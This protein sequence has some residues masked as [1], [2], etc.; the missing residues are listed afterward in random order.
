MS[1]GVAN[2]RLW[3]LAIRVHS[4]GAGRLYDLFAEL[5]NGADLQDVLERFAAIAVYRD[6]SRADGGDRLCGLRSLEGEHQQ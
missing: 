4:L 2:V 3:R 5:E 1:A 6:F